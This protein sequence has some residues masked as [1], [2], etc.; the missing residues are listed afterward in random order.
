[1][2]VLWA[3]QRGLVNKNQNGGHKTNAPFK[4]MMLKS[5]NC[6]VDSL[7][8]LSTLCSVNLLNNG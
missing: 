2:G 6:H 7:L 8:G 4:F 5:R 3:G 1:M